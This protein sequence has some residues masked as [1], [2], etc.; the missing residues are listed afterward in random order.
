M[1]PLRRT[2][3]ALAVAATVVVAPPAALAL[4]LKTGT[5]QSIGIAN[6]G[7]SLFRVFLG[8]V[9]SMCTGDQYGFA[10]LNDDVTPG[11]KSK[12]AG[13]L[14]AYTTAKPVQLL[15]NPTNGSCEIVEIGF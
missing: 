10:F 9:T 8:G 6:P 4:E 14:V 5:I 11:H 15:V 1:T 12:I 3:A 7:N 13:L 2:F